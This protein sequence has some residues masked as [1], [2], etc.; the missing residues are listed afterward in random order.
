MSYPE[1]RSLFL[2][3][4]GVPPGDEAPDPG[5]D[6]EFPN[7]LSLASSYLRCFSSLSF[8][9]LACRSSGVNWGGLLADSESESDRFAL[10][11]L[12]LRFDIPSPAALMLLL[13]REAI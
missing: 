5:A 8:N 7:N 11:P 4:G 9:A 10:L 6:D 1:S 13:F 2:D 3:G 12:M